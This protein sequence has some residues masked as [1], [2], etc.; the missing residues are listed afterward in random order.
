VGHTVTLLTDGRVLVAGGGRLANGTEAIDMVEIFDPA[1]ETFAA[2][3]PMN[4]ARAQH[5]ATILADGRVLVVSGIQGPDVLTSAEVFDVATSR[6]TD[7]ADAH[8]PRQGFTLTLLSDGRA[9][10]VGGYSQGTRTAEVYDPVSGTWQLTGEMSAVRGYHTAT[11]L[12]D[13]RVL[14]AGGIDESQAMLAS[15]ELWLSPPP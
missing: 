10:S 1:T 4:H 15:T 11:L 5:A 12:L 14:V 7:V 2:V 9:L 8:E 6:W 3:P 13:G